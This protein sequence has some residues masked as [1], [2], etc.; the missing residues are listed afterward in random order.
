M[1]SSNFEFH[2]RNIGFHDVDHSGGVLLHGETL[3]YSKRVVGDVDVE[4]IE[5]FV[6][7]FER[8]GVFDLADFSLEGFP[9][10]G[11]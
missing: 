4:D 3:Q 9:D 8:I 6:M 10:E 2:G 11:L 5:E 7:V 1:S